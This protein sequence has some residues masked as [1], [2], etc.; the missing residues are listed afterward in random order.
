MCH[1]F[2]LFRF[3]CLLVTREICQYVC[4]VWHSHKFHFTQYLHLRTINSLSHLL[5]Y[6]GVSWVFCFD[7]SLNLLV[8][9]PNEMHK[10]WI[11]LQASG[12]KSDR[13]EVKEGKCER[14]EEGKGEKLSTG[15]RGM[16]D[17]CNRI[18]HKNA[19]SVASSLGPP[20][21][22]QILIKRKDHMKTWSPRRDQRRHS[23]SLWL[24]LCR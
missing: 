23:V 10:P 21:L 2:I 5:L 9:W 16:E 8:V 19:T 11:K 24:H 6:A 1:S 18:A 14:T 4:L 3:N 22:M 20:T 17:I 13:E 15:I 12:W 7:S